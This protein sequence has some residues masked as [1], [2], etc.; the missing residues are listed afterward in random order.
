MK[1]LKLL[2]LLPL[3][4][5]LVGCGYTVEQSIIDIKMCEEAGL[6]Y[7]KIDYRGEVRCGKQPSTVNT[8]PRQDVQAC[9]DNGGVPYISSWDGE[10]KECQ[11]K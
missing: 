8:Q 2:L 10:L 1:K 6:D 11:Y 3:V 7:Y 9:I 5:V 4:F